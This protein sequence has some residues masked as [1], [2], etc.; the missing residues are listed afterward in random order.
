M[1]SDKVRP[2]HLERK[3]IL[4]VR[5]SCGPRLITAAG[6]LGGAG[7]SGQKRLRPGAGRHYVPDPRGPATA[8]NRRSRFGKTSAAPLGAKARAEHPGVS[9]LMSA[10]FPLPARGW[11]RPGSLGGACVPERIET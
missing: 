1:I 11:I 2:H 8:L 7:L 5:Q 6:G 9:G 3:A 10:R 4:Y